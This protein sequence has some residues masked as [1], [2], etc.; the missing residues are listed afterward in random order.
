MKAITNGEGTTIVSLSN[1]G[2]E[3]VISIS[4]LAS[5]EQRAWLLGQLA[6]GE[7]MEESLQ[8]MAALMRKKNPKIKLVEVDR[9]IPFTEFWESY[10]YKV[11][12]K[13]AVERRW[14]AMPAAERT[15]A[16][17]YIKKY[18]YFLAEHPAIERKYPLTYLNAEECN[19]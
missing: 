2:E 1:N 18:N 9:D 10:G 15:K 5:A 8:N 19:N 14:A 11:G 6:T 7:N 12:K 4:N 13:A 3:Y 16:A 17:Q